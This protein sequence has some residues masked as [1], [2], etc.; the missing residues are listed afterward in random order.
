MFCAARS[1]SGK[2]ALIAS[3]LNPFWCC[4]SQASHASFPES[5]GVRQARSNKV[6]SGVGK[7]ADKACDNAVLEEDKTF[8]LYIPRSSSSRSAKNPL[9]GGGRLSLLS[10]LAGRVDPDFVDRSNS[11]DVK[12]PPVLVSPGAIRRLFRRD[13]SS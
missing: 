12:A 1:R 9:F 2:K 11:R 8:I 4:L 13:N 6:S 10:F 3:F 5:P 7:I